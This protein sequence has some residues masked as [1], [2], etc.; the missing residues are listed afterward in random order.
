MVSPEAVSGVL[1]HAGKLSSPFND[2]ILILPTPLSVNPV[3]ICVTHVWNLFF[4][5]ETE[6]FRLGRI[7]FPSTL[8]LHIRQMKVIMVTE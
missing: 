3:I 7:P 2:R 8:I 6:V 5:M 1:G 4:L